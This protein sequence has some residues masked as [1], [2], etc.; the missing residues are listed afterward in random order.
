MEC[1]KVF[2]ASASKSTSK[3]TQ[4]TIKRHTERE[5]NTAAVCKYIWYYSLLIVSIQLQRV[6][7][8][9]R[10]SFWWNGRTRQSRSALRNKP[11]TIE[12]LHQRSLK[13]QRGRVCVVHLT[14]NTCQTMIHIDPTS[15]GNGLTHQCRHAAALRDGTQSHHLRA[16]ISRREEKKQKC[17]TKQYACT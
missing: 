1:C 9:C 2:R 3:P 5:K 14:C 6:S 10:Y 4:F 8:P 15:D 16:K 12:R 13:Q 17:H 7:A 11:V